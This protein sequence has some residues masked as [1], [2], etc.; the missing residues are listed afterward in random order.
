M[1]IILREMSAKTWNF[2]RK[3]ANIVVRLRSVKQ[4]AICASQQRFAIARSTH[5]KCVKRSYPVGNRILTALSLFNFLAE[6]DRLLVDGVL[7]LYQ[8]HEY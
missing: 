4:S 1:P 8:Q 6:L 3:V 7:Q 2:D 5:A